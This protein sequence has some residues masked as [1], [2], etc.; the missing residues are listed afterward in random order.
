MSLNIGCAATQDLASS[1]CFLVILFPKSLRL[2]NSSGDISES[3]TV[4][5]CVLSMNLRS[6]AFLSIGFFSTIGSVVDCSKTAG[7]VLGCSSKVLFSCIEA[8]ADVSA[9]LITG[10]LISESPKVIVLFIELGTVAPKSLLM[11]YSL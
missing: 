4:L 10:R 9:P 1:F 5:A 7:S 2:V 11:K 6:L 8:V 3:L